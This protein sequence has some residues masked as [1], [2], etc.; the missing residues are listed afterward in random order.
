MTG[1]KPN[2][3]RGMKICF[4]I[5]GTNIGAGFA[6]GR[7]IW[8]FFGSYGTNS[9]LYLVISMVLFSVCSMIVLWISWK[10]RTDHYYSVLTLIMGKRMAGFFDGLI[11]LY[12]V[13]STL[14]M[15]AGSGATFS[16]WDMSFLLGS[17]VLALA[18]WL[19]LFQDVK[20]LMSLNYFLMPCLTVILVT[21]CLAFLV[22]GEPQQVAVH[23][24]ME[25]LPVWPSAVTYAALNVI[26][27]MAVLATLGK[28]IGHPLEIG[29]AGVGS[30]VC[31]GVVA[32]LFNMSLLRVENIIPQYD[33]PL[34]ALIDAYS[35]VWL[36]VI[37]IIL[38][39][40][41]YTTAV[42]GIYGAV[43]RISGWIS[44]PRSVIA[45]VI[46]TVLIPL[47]QLGFA[48][49]VK[50]IY[51]LYGIINLFVLSMILLYP[52]ARAR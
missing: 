45:L 24:D 2:I 31:L 20:G 14:V 4:T 25:W 35:A 44:V 40:A 21:V 36:A 26:P 23:T 38:W 52:F 33:I 8:E 10:Q 3:Q 43:S 11:L 50:V 7:E 49:L 19:I 30:G 17:A 22:H 39:L 47:S 32:V 29:I 34:F 9:T 6:S 46:V 42:S 16:Q 5:V 28:E 27:L 41:I 15:F 37:S 18:V 51:P 1:V 48:T 13:S 12:L